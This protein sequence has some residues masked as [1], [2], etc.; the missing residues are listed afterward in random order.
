[1]N[2]KKTFIL[3]VV[4]AVAVLFVSCGGGGGG[5]GGAAYIP[6]SNVEATNETT[7]EQQTVTSSNS[8]SINQPQCVNAEWDFNLHVEHCQYH[9]FNHIEFLETGQFRMTGSDPSVPIL[10]YGDYSI[11]YFGAARVFDAEYV[12]N[13][14]Y[15]V[16][17]SVNI[18]ENNHLLGVTD[19][20]EEAL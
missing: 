10:M 9:D 12:T 15:L 20:S 13:L 1:M 6:P 17:F 2:M 7:V 18:D 11:R 19:F 3:S 14:C 5:A 4:L 8:N 16:K